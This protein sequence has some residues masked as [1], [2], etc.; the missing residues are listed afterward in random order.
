M[1]DVRANGLVA[2]GQFDINA[3]TFKAV[4]VG[5][6]SGIGTI[7]CAQFGVSYYDLSLNPWGGNVGI[8]IGDGVAPVAKLQV[9]GAGTGSGEIF[10]ATDSAGVIKFAVVDNGIIWLGNTKTPAGTTGTQT[11]NKP[12]GS[13]NI[14]AGQSSI[15]INNT[16]ATL[17]GY[18]FAS[19]A[20]ADATAV[21]KNV[22]VTA[23][24]ITINLSAAATSETKIN[25]VIF[26]Y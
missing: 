14:A 8:G 19:I 4:H 21:I 25:F 15:T 1:G 17:N 23:G 3:Q 9:K 7:Q 13:V 22:V 12:L 2:S 20:T 24:V 18:A 16:L 26:N 6:R 11:I 5:I 10:R